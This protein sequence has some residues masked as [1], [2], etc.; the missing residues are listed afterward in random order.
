MRTVVYTFV[1]YYRHPFVVVILSNAD[2]DY[3]DVER[4]VQERYQKRKR[5]R[6]TPTRFETIKRYMNTSR[7]PRHIARSQR[8]EEYAPILI[9]VPLVSFRG[10]VAGGAF[11]VF[12]V[13]R[14]RGRGGGGG[15]IARDG[16]DF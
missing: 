6:K 10:C 15:G 9:D 3:F 2:V 11:V 12:V 14:R 8:M 13:S 1:A 7:V 4:F 16:H 5:R